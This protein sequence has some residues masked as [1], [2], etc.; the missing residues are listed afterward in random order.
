MFT[1]LLTLTSIFYTL[2]QT[3]STFYSD[4][5]NFNF[6]EIEQKILWLCLFL[7]FATKI[8]IIPFHI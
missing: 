1:A 8:P 7:T 5:L 3:G 4:I 2:M 6:T